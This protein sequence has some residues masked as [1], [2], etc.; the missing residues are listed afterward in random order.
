MLVSSPLLNGADLMM[1]GVRGVQRWREGL[2]EGDVACVMVHG[3]PAPLAVGRLLVSGAAVLSALSAAQ[4]VQ[5][6]CLEVLHV[7]GDALWKCAP[8]PHTP[9]LNAGAGASIGTLP[10]AVES[11][12]TARLT[13]RPRRARK[14]LGR[15]WNSVFGCS[16]RQEDQSGCCSLFSAGKH[17][18]AEKGNKS[19]LS[20][21]HSAA[22]PR[23]WSPPPASIPVTRY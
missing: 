14:G 6:R 7:F 16:R 2:G 12:A 21:S 22:A 20:L 8:P 18:P 11:A 3:N 10:R 1:P 9:R 17:P 5:G 19:L 13:P 4:L 23:N 15:V